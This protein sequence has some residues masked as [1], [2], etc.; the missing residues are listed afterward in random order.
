MCIV[1]FL[2]IE[3]FPAVGVVAVKSIQTVN[4][5]HPL[6]AQEIIKTFHK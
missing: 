1:S 5:K 2:N 6:R 3:P 4:V